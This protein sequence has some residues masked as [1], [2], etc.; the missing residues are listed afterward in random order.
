MATLILTNVKAAL[1]IK[2]SSVQRNFKINPAFGLNPGGDARGPVLVDDDAL[3][4]D[5]VEAADDPHVGGEAGAGHVDHGAA[6]HVTIFGGKRER[7]V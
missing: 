3:G 6:Q 2:W 7:Q 4:V 1:P 5:G